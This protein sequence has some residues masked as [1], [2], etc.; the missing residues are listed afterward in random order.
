MSTQIESRF[1]ETN[2][3][4]HHYLTGGSG[5]LVL[6]CHGFPELSW[7]WRHQ[8]PALAAAGY[9][10]VAPDMR[11]YGDTKGPVD[12]RAYTNL[13]VLGDMVAL[14]DA[15]GEKQAVIVGHDWGSPIAW[16]A[17]TLRPDRFRAVASLSVMHNPRMPMS[18]PDFAK[19]N[20]MA[21]LYWLY[22]QP[23]GQAEADMERH[24]RETF[25][26]LMYGVSGDA[27][28]R[29]ESWNLRVDPKVG[30]VNSL[31]RPNA[32]PAWL[33][34]DDLNRYA[35]TYARTGF[36]TSLNWYRCMARSWQL[37]AA[38]ADVKVSVPALFIGGR[39]DP[40]LTQ[41]QSGTD[42]MR[43]VVTDLRDVIMVDAGH[44]V[45]QEDPEAVSAGLIR[46]LK[47]L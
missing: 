34:E 30:L 2:G 33:T 29:G 17:A 16:L 11:G 20:D 43:S 37:S 15:L 1:I 25:L 31:V 42:A 36:T 47:G 32:L 3:L 40:T 5:P 8:I 26:R 28:Q 22:F 4:R 23:P 9:Q 6:L 19:A 41:L 39:N 14:L 13:D 12:P 44:W 24:T 21:D 18:P 27:A 45:Q 46:F 7:S 10:V 35:G 38:W